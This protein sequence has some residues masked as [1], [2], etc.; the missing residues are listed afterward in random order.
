MAKDDKIIVPDDWQPAKPMTYCATDYETLDD[1]A[2]LLPADELKECVWRSIEAA[3]HAHEADY[4]GL[5]TEQ[6]ICL[7]HLTRAH[8]RRLEEYRATS[9]KRSKHNGGGRPEKT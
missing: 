4:S 7:K 8:N 1:F 3:W 5:S 2:E 6:K 9:F